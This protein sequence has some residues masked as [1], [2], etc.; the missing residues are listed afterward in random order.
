MR[1][2]FNLTFV[3]KDRIGSGYGKASPGPMVNLFISGSIWVAEPQFINDKLNDL[4]RF[5][6]ICLYIFSYLCFR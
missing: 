1:F 3:P 2:E 6:Q 5:K 4:E